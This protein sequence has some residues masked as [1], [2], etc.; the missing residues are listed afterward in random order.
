MSAS[1]RSVSLVP[2]DR[3]RT[4]HPREVRELLR[5]R[6]NLLAGEDRALIAM[7]LEGGETLRRIATLAS[8][9]PS[10]V[11][12]RIRTITQR[13]ADPTYPAC[14]AR[15]GHFSTLELRIIRDYFIRGRSIRDIHRRRGLGR[16][17]VRT[18]IRKA[19]ACAL[20]SAAPA[21]AGSQKG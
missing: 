17:R 19:R 15:R 9:T 21:Q 20:A 6:G 12:R 5:L 4:L 13:L 1:G 2:S 18:V 7:Y 14:R 3:S 10:C 8:V 11:A 16:H